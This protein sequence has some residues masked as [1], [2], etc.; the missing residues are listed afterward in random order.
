MFSAS[1]SLAV[2][3]WPGM[4]P[5]FLGNSPLHPNLGASQWI[6]LRRQ[7]LGT[8]SWRVCCQE[9]V[10]V[11]L[12]MSSHQIFKFEESS[13]LLN[14]LTSCS[15]TWYHSNESRL[16][17]QPPCTIATMGQPYVGDVLA[18]YLVSPHLC[19]TS[20]W[21]D[22][23]QGHGLPLKVGTRSHKFKLFPGGTTGDQVIY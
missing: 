7:W 17:V 5:W 10:W 13:A 23:G 20:R 22:R 16:P 21:P 18:T 12:S 4:H 2:L 3:D 1:A 9:N 6:T 11:F 15:S 8:C 19:L 14:N